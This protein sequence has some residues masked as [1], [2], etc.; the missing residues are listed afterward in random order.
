M[1]RGAPSLPSQHAASAR[2]PR[3]QVVSSELASLE[4]RAGALS[5]ELLHTQRRLAAAEQLARAREAEVEDMRSA[6]EA[7]AGEHRRAQVGARRRRAAA[8]P[9]GGG[10]APAVS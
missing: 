2:A 4:Q 8:G 9:R 10:H 5:E 3:A 1:P 7:L 6:Y